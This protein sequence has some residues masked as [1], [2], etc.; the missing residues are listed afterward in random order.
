MCV[1][2][3]EIGRCARR[4]T[5]APGCSVCVGRGVCVCV[6]VC[7]YEVELGRCARTA[8][9]NMEAGCVRARARVCVCVCVRA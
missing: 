7:V 1:C 2:V 3:V 8:P 9:A 6:C 5:S 4:G